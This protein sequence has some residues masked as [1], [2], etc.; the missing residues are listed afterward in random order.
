MAKAGQAAP[1]PNATFYG[2]ELKIGLGSQPTAQIEIGQLQVV[3]NGT[4]RTTV[5]AYPS[6]NLVLQSTGAGGSQ[7]VSQT[8][9]N[10]FEKYAFASGGD[11]TN[12]I[13][14][15]VLSSTLGFAFNVVNTNNKVAKVFAAWMKVT[16]WWTFPGGPV[17]ALWG[18][19]FLSVL[20]TFLFSTGVPTTTASTAPITTAAIDTTPYGLIIGVS[21]GGA[22]LAAGLVVL[23]VYLARR[24]AVAQPSIRLD[25]PVGIWFLVVVLLIPHQMTEY[26]TF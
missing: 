16:V 3:V 14:N 7:V 5:V 9:G 19:A 24:A 25:A 21:V 2:L 17:G 13:V 18:R 4:Y 22:V 6:V 11:A 26:K 10:P 12:L 20:V 15:G 23:I 8:F 1:F